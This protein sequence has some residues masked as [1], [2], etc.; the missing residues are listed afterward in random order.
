MI[1]DPTTIQVAKSKKPPTLKQRVKDLEQEVQSLMTGFQNLQQEVLNL[2]E[3]VGG[4]P[5]YGAGCYPA[6]GSGTFEGSQ[7]DVGFEGLFC[8][9]GGMEELTGAIWI[10]A[11]PLSAENETWATG[12]L[13]A[14]GALH[15]AA[16]GNPVGGSGPMVVSVIGAVGEVPAIVP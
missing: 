3:G 12:T 11:Q 6:S 15:V 8:S 10:V 7:Y 9:S 5:F 16:V 1:A 13:V 14:S 2:E 4:T